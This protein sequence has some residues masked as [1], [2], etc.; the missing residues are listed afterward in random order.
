MKNLKKYLVI[1]IMLIM[2]FSLTGCSN[3][4]KNSSNLKN[5][6][7]TAGGNSSINKGHHDKESDFSLYHLDRETEISFVE[8]DIDE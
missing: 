6:N 7:S 4:D 2:I 3:D 5:T 8:G 1:I